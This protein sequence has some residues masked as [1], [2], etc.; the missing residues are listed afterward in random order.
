MQEGAALLDAVLA[1]Q[2]SAAH[3]ASSAS[4]TKLDDVKNHTDEVLRTLPPPLLVENASVVRNPF[5]AL[6]DGKAHPLGSVLRQEM[7]RYN[8]LRDVL[9]TSL[10]QLA[11][12][13]QGLAIMSTDLEAMLLS[14]T[15]NQVRSC[16]ETPRSDTGGG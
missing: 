16:L 4:G 2:P 9:E 10:Q 7:D 11:K 1:V 3:S 15:N 8:R 6:S 5:K 12:A 13:V 14:F